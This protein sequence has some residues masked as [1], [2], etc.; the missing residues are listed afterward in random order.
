MIIIVLTYRMI[1]KVKLKEIAYVKCFE[2]AQHPI[3]TQHI[4][5]VVVTMMMMMIFELCEPRR[6]QQR[7]AREGRGM[8]QL[9]GRSMGLGRWSSRVGL[10]WVTHPP[11]HGGG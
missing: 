11:W 10:A 2:Y 4:L 1:V 7:H 5:V 6:H 8:F 9:G 3:I